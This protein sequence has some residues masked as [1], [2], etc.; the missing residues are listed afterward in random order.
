MI[1]YS[2]FADDLCI[3]ESATSSYLVDYPMI[4]NFN[5]TRNCS[6]QPK[7]GPAYFG[8]GSCAKN[9]YTSNADYLF[10]TKYFDSGFMVERKLIMLWLYFA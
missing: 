6:G 3:P 8:P 9:P 7:R 10:N 1:S 4:S 5:E 2:G